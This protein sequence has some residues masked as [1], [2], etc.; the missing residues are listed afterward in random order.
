[1]CGVFVCG[2]SGIGCVRCRS[3]GRSAAN[4]E[5]IRDADSASIVSWN[6]GILLE[7]RLP[8]SLTVTP[9]LRFFSPSPLVPPGLTTPAMASS[10]SD[11]VVLAVGI[12]LAAVY[13]FREQIFTGKPKSAPV[14]SAKGSASN[15]N[16]RDFIAK[17]KEGVSPQ[18]DRHPPPPVL[19]LPRR[20]EK[21]HRHLLRFANGHG[22]GIRHSSRKGGQVQVRT[23]L[24]RVRPGRV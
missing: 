8:S 16:P 12:I 3:G 5:D 24:A 18:F 23:C 7:P 6:E 13:L 17:M 22:G 9:L 20:T 21:A 15:G 14:P 11:V 4:S 1:M 2:S 19:T 10:S